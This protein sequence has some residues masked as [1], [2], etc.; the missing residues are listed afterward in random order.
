MYFVSSDAVLCITSAIIYSVL[1]GF[2]T[3]FM[4]INRSNDGM[5]INTHWFP[6]IHMIRVAPLIHAVPLSLMIHVIPMVLMVLIIPV[7]LIAVISW[8]LQFPEFLRFLV[9]IPVI[10]WFLLFCYVSFMYIM[11]LVI[12]YSSP[13]LIIH[14][15]LWIPY[16]S[17]GILIHA[18]LL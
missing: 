9:L 18:A 15:V 16:D 10:P 4:Y 17:D 8:F 3:L 6:L 14:V 2:L 1:Y 12:L 5:R 7:V 13:A 11:V